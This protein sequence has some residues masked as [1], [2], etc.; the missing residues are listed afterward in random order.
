MAGRMTIDGTETFVRWL[1]HFT[2]IAKKH[3]KAKYAYRVMPFIGGLLLINWEKIAIAKA[4]GYP[5]LKKFTTTGGRLY[6]KRE[7]DNTEFTFK[8]SHD[9][10][11][12][13]LLRKNGEIIHQFDN[14]SSTEWVEDVMI[15]LLSGKLN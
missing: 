7:C 11:K 3:Y 4:S 8:F 14:C 6:I 1:T 13:Q 9:D 2:T 15:D 12:I 5:K 10:R